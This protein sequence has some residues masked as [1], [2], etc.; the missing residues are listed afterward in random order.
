M[1]ILHSQFEISRV[2]VVFKFNVCL[3][4]GIVFYLQCV[5]SRNY[6]VCLNVILA[7]TAFTELPVDPGIH[8]TLNRLLGLRCA[9]HGLRD[10]IR[11]RLR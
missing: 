8:Q 6:V 9:F 11:L 5:V 2:P 7:T 3:R 1:H 4:F 10:L